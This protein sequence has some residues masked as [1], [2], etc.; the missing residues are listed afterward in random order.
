MILNLPL[1]W[2]SLQVTYHP[3]S[4]SCPHLLYPDSRKKEWLWEEKSFRN[5]FL[6]SNTLNCLNMVLE[7]IWP[8]AYT[9]PLYLKD[10]GF[11]RY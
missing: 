3:C 4:Q 11:L 1:H 5:N 8:I 7:E 2:K 10:L 6:K 9:L